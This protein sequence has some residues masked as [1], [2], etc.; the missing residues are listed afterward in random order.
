[1]FP[2]LTAKST[3]FYVIFFRSSPT[4]RSQKQTKASN[5][6]TAFG[7]RAAI[8]ALLMDACNPSNR[9]LV[10]G[11][12]SRL[13]AMF[14]APWFFFF[15]WR[16]DRCRCEFF[17]FPSFSHF[18]TKLWYF[19]VALVGIRTADLFPLSPTLYPLDHTPPIHR[20]KRH[21]KSLSPAS[22]QDAGERRVR[23]RRCARTPCLPQGD[24]HGTEVPGVN[25]MIRLLLVD[26]TAVCKCCFE[27]KTV[28]V[29]HIP[30][31]PGYVGRTR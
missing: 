3:W 15:A 22:E 8:N 9:R 6:P 5:A 24:L 25:H 23:E 18:A 31:P 16:C 29:P 21:G 26:H 17:F 20:Y 12:K 19:F 27:S 2:E 30:L 13:H 11:G 28:D 10:A 1:M 4:R 14:I 7:K